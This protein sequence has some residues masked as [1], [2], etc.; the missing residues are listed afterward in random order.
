MMNM[1]KKV[2]IAAISL[3]TVLGTGIVIDRSRQDYSAHVFISSNGWGYDIVKGRKTIIHQPFIP[4]FAGNVTFGDKMTA[5]R[6]GD[7]I[8]EKLKNKQSPRVSK[9][10][11]EAVLNTKNE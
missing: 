1:I 3:L 8:V 6:T 9:L 10:E 11:I 7:L 2:V 4:C 5:Q